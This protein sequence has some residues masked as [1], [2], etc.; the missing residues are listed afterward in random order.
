MNG[1]VRF[2]VGSLF[3]AVCTPLALADSVS[4]IGSVS[5][6]PD[7]LTFAPPFATGNNSG[8]FSNFSGGTVNYLLGT[9]PYVDGVP[10]T[11]LAFTITA[12]NGDVLSFYDQVNSPLK[13]YDG[14]GNLDVAL[15]ETGYYTVN[16]GA[17]MAGSFDLNLLGTS[18]T[19][20]DA[21]VAFL[22]TGE[23]FTPTPAAVT[24]EPGSILL[25]GTGLLGAAAV[26][27]TRRKAAR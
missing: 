23:L 18:S 4:V 2:V 16:G 7:C 13:S 12:G 26:L 14:N 5:F 20:A 8:L 9:V 24:P 3:L 17:E 6:T 15:N 11:E 10:Q 21:K 19:G 27:Q 25:F 22:G 1:P